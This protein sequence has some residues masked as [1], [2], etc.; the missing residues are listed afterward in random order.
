MRLF[1]IRSDL[2]YYRLKELSDEPVAQSMLMGSGWKGMAV[3]GLEGQL[4]LLEAASLARTQI[5]WL[6]L[7]VQAPKS[8]SVQ[9]WQARSKAAEIELAHLKAV[10][11]TLELLEQVDLARE[12]D[13]AIVGGSGL[14]AVAVMHRFSRNLDPHLHVH[15]LIANQSEFSGRALALDHGRLARILPALELAY[16]SELREGLRSI[17]IELQGIGL[18][19]WRVVG[20]DPDLLERFSTRRLEVVTNALGSSAKARQVAVYQTRAPKGR[21]TMEEATRRLEIRGKEGDTGKL[22]FAFDP[23]RPVVADPFWSEFIKSAI[24]SDGGVREHLEST[25]RRLLAGARAQR[26]DGIPAPVVY[27][28][29]FARRYR[30]IDLMER[31]RLAGATRTPE[32]VAVRSLELQD[33]ANGVAGGTRVLARSEKEKE[34]IEAVAQRSRL[35]FDKATFVVDASCIAP[36]DLAEEANRFKIAITDEGSRLKSPVIELK[37]DSGTLVASEGAGSLWNA[38]ITDASR[39]LAS[40]RA[41]EYLLVDNH[42]VAAKLRR[43]MLSR[44]QELLLGKVGHRLALKG[45]RV[46]H[47]ELGY[48]VLKALDANRCEVIFGDGSY[49]VKASDITIDTVRTSSREGS[50]LYFGTR[51]SEQLGI[52]RAYV[53]ADRIAELAEYLGRS[54]EGGMR[55]VG[56]EA[57]YLELVQLRRPIVKALSK[58]RNFEMM[59]PQM[60]SIDRLTDQ[61]SM[62]YQRSHRLG[63]NSRSAYD[64]RIDAAIGRTRAT[65]RGQAISRSLERDSFEFFGRSL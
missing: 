9:A 38:F 61:L 5:K 14:K 21:L 19:T 1:K 46:Y 50:A 40:G 64:M 36:S 4:R 3:D 59:R 51:I 55:L 16:R 7:I 49:Q 28:G 52:K 39:L 32:L 62:L 30:S 29:S 60:E 6:D 18:E 56:S 26:L 31:L 37:G 20:Q 10:E 2:D 35:P 24:S 43:E 53:V 8:V 48:G 44:N 42:V 34:L 58:A 22:S 17:G 23:I 54:E 65:G 45:D 27:D 25:F 11:A 12:V 15:L 41:E 47:Q 57:S 63:L 13:G 33:V